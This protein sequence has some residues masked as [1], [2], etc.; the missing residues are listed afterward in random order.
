MFVRLEDDREVG[1]AAFS[2][3]VIVRPGLDDDPPDRELA[4]TAGALGGGG[5]SEAPPDPE[6]LDTLFGKPDVSSSKK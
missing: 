3:S 6:P 5:T 1:R 2:V 4:E